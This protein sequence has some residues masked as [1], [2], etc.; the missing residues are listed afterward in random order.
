MIDIL[1]DMEELL[2][3]D[4]HFLLSNWL[5]SAKSK[6]VNQEESFMYEWNART[7]ITLWGVNYTSNVSSF[8]TQITHFELL[9]VVFVFL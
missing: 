2:A 4:K 5:E 8:F 9:G 7:Q 1:S 6:A 3:T